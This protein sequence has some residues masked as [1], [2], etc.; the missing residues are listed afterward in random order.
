M[1]NKWKISGHTFYIDNTT[2][3]F[4]NDKFLRGREGGEEGGEGGEG[5]VKEPGEGE[6]DF[7]E[8]L[9]EEMKEK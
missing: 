3:F 8:D 1:E 9:K 2:I 5:G 6:D 4:R 7:L